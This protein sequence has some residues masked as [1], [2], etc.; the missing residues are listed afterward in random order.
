WAEAEA[1]AAVRHPHVVQVFELGEHDGRP[2]MALEYLPGGTLSD[3]LAG[4]RLAPADAAALLAKLAGAVQAA[5]DAGIVHRDLKPDNV[6]FGP[7]G[8]P[9]VTDFG[10]AKRGQSDLTRTQ[11]VMG[12]PAYMAPEQAKGEAKF[13]G[14]AADTYALGVILYGCRPGPR[15][16]AGDEPWSVPRRVIAT[17]PAPPRKRAPGLPRALELICLKCLAKRPADRSPTAD[18]LADD[19]RRF[20]DGR[21]VSVR[22]AGPR[23]R[24]TEG[25]RRNPTHAPLLAGLAVGARTRI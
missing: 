15:P 1:M 4:G 17:D 21:P 6:L 25:G 22:P 10:I 23:E 16:S 5:H 18:A 12:T 19:L 24:L 9:K 13:V 8:E 3:L 2:F 7:D 20:L 14:P 11:A